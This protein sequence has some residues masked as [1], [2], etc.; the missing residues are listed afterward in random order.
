[1]I[2]SMVVICLMVIFL[3]GCEGNNPIGP[4]SDGIYSDAPPNNMYVIPEKGLVVSNF[5]TSVDNNGTY[6]KLNSKVTITN[7]TSRPLYIKGYEFNVGTCG[8]EILFGVVTGLDPIPAYGSIESA[9]NEI[10]LSCKLSKGNYPI[11]IRLHGWFASGTFYDS[12]T[13]I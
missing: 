5:T 3:S 13:V 7:K 2:K 4:T 9:Y 11:E 12:F 1:M 8:E 6:T 10:T